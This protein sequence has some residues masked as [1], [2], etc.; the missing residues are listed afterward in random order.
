MLVIGTSG[1]VHP[2]ASVP[3]WA[4]HGGA[5]VIEINVQRTPISAY[6]DEVILGPAAVEV[7]K[8]WV[9]WRR[10]LE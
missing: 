7:A 9:K 6:A 3:L 5:Y 10:A 2:A 1:V 8:L 4:K